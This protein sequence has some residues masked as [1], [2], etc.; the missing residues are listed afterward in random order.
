ME[1]GQPGEH[2]HRKTAGLG[3]CACRECDFAV[4]GVTSSSANMVGKVGSHMGIDVKIAHRGMAVG[5][6]MPTRRKAEEGGAELGRPVLNK[7]VGPRVSPRTFKKMRKVR[8]NK[9]G[10]WGV[11]SN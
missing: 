10:R 3:W 5:V 4:R 1:L 6:G 2:A 7:M 9:H 11:D 8:E